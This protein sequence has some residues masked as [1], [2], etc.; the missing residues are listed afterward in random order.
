MVEH[1]VE[2]KIDL[3]DKL[4]NDI[5]DGWKLPIES[6]F[7]IMELINYFYRVNYLMSELLGLALDFEDFYQAISCT[8]CNSG[9]SVSYNMVDYSD[10]NN[11]KSKL[12]SILIG[13]QKIDLDETR[14]ENLF[15]LAFIMNEGEFRYCINSNLFVNKLLSCL[16]NIQENVINDFSEI[17]E[18]NRKQN[19]ESYKV[20]HDNY[21]IVSINKIY[22][23]SNIEVLVLQKILNRISKNGTLDKII[24]ISKQL[25]ELKLKICNL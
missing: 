25:C 21:D 14:M 9:E 18:F 3:I 8:T 23:N 5:V 6:G 16:S 20:I 24:T 11:I 19:R 7:I 4:K 10:I 15:M 17:M 22:N 1:S 13:L 2:H 12:D